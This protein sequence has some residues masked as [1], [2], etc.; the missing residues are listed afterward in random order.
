MAVSLLKS[1]ANGCISREFW[2]RIQPLGLKD[3][4]RSLNRMFSGRLACKESI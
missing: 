3:I 4:S 2:T 1:Y